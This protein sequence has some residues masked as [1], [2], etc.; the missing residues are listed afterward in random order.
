MEGGHDALA[1]VVLYANGLGIGRYVE[2]I[3]RHAK[4]EKS[5]R[6]SVRALGKAHGQKAARIKESRQHDHA[7]TAIAI[8]KPR[9]KSHGAYLA[10][11]NRE[12]H[13]PQ[14]GIS[15]GKGTLD[16][17]NTICPSGKHQSLDEEK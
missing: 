8:D 17:G 15:E 13:I 6:E 3:S 5:Y 4:K 16:V 12:Q 7:P 9:G 1:I 11:R 10:Y 2:E 14:L